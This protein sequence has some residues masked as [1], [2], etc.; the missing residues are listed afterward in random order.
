MRIL[1]LSQW[2]DPEP[3]FKGLLFARELARRGH[4]V[5]VLTGFPNYPGGKLYPGYRIRPWRREILDGI[6]VVRVALYPSHDRSSWRRALNYA[7]FALGASVLGPPL[8][9]RPDVVYTYHPPA[10]VALPALVIKMLL[11]IPVV[12]DIQD[13]WPDT[14][15]ASGMVSGRR[16]LAMLGRWCNFVYRRMDQLIVLSPGFRT[17]LLSRGLQPGK[18]HVI[19]NWC[20]EERISAPG[21]EPELTRELGF[22]DRFNIVFAGTMGLAQNLQ[23]VLEAARICRERCPA[24]RFVFV[25]GGIEKARLEALARGMALDNVVFLERQPVER[26][27]RILALAD[28]LLVHL[29]DDPLFCITIPSK[30]Q[31]YMAAGKPILMAVRGDAAELV[32]RAG[33]GLSCEP[34][35]ALALADAVTRMSAMPQAELEAMGAAGRSFYER[36]LSL[37]A[38]VDRFEEVFHA[39]VQSTAVTSRFAL[40]QRVKRAFDFTLALSALCLLS[41]VLALAAAAI[42]VNM[43]SPIL[44]RQ[45]RPGWRERPFAMLKL[46]TMREPRPQEHAPDAARLTRLGALLRK[47][48]LDELPQLWN[49]VKGDMS[50][51]GPRPLLP[52]YLPRY[53]DHQ[54]RRHEVKPGITGWAQVHG[55]NAL[56]WEQK[57]ELDVWYVDHQSLWLDIK[58]LFL[59]ALKVLSRDGI[60]QQGHATMSE[61]LGSPDQSA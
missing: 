23:T 34:E 45:V 48:S 59:T 55:R 16:I 41:P 3:T 44:F 39:A 30:T 47:L 40:G 35:N 7:T 21:R 12:Y 61:F 17:I 8:V 54:R 31:A 22:A 27:G 19:Y 60:S 1:I 46:R 20:D 26:I 49:V 10:T 53:N 15:R 32:E 24:A 6:R 4:D 38:G 52:E 56:T 18:V 5:E 57:F 42:R 36:E 9:K 13:L 28:V 11:R 2:F 50:L 51:V 25:G 58:I 14:V 33:A 29:K 43:G 37:R